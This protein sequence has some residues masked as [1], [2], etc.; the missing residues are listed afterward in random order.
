MWILTTM[1]STSVWN[2]APAGFL[3][4]IDKEFVRA[5]T[6]IGQ[7]VLDVSTAYRTRISHVDLPIGVYRYFILDR[8][9][10]EEEVCDL[11]G[12]E[13]LPDSIEGSY[14]VFDDC[15]LFFDSITE[16]EDA[17]NLFNA[18]LDGA[19]LSFVSLSGDPELSTPEIYLTE[20][21]EHA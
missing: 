19:L 4:E 18:R 9:A 7:A 17:E 21:E 11:L 15:P 14:C 3:I 1:Y 8:G 12:I 10:H 13:E 6:A 5:L 2:Q 20:L 16:D